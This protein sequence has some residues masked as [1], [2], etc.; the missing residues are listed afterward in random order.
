MKS[1]EKRFEGTLKELPAILQWAHQQGI[2]SGLSPEATAQIELALEEALVNVV[3]HAYQESTGHIELVFRL[4]PKSRIEFE[5]RDI[6]PFFNPLEHKVSLDRSI[7]I[8]KQREGGLGILLMKRL[9]DELHY[10]R[11]EPYNVL[12]LVKLIV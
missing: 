4:H 12:I 1:E 6:G 8:E 10:R 2:E 11:E 7:P 9:V 3:S 5:I